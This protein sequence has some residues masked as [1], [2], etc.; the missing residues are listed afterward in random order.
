ML[1]YSLTAAT[2]AAGMLFKFKHGPK[3]MIAGGVLGGLLGTVAGCVIGGL[4]TI[5]GAHIFIN[6]MLLFNSLI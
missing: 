2:A 3:P 4:L 5:T 1:F 6:L